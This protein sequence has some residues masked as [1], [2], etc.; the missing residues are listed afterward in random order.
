MPTLS[1]EPHIVAGPNAGSRS[2]RLLQVTW[3][4]T[5][6]CHWKSTK[7]RASGRAARANYGFSTAEAFHL[8]EQVADLQVPLLVLTGGDPLLRPDLFPIVEFAA[9]RSVRTSLTLL[10]TLLVTRET[11]SKL[12]ER[13]LMR[14]NFWMH[15]S[16]AALDDAQWNVRGCHRRTVEAVG[17]CHEVEL[18]VQINTMLSRRNVRDLEPMVDLLM[19]LDVALW[20]VFFLVP[21]GPEQQGEVLNAEEHEQAFAKLYAAQK[22]VQFQIKTTEGPQYQRYV[23]QKSKEIRGRDP[24]MDAITGLPKGVDDG[25][26]SVFINPLG[27]VLPSRFLPLSGGN[28]TAKPLAEVYGESQLFRSLRDRTKLKGKCCRCTFRNVCGGSRARVY[29]MTGDL[30]AE[31]PCCAYK[32]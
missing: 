27:E 3:E 22:R 6:A 20:N 16:T 7:V 26:S 15:G 28:V 4:M 32:A 12:K 19:R 30:F 31:D 17:F 1:A 5:Q 11:I 9:Q 14:L 24:G 8:I 13:G 10:P 21:S 2:T 29:A 25:K 18:P 23:Q